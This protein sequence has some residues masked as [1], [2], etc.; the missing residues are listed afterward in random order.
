[1]FIDTH[2]HLDLTDGKENIS[3]IVARA[4][5]AQVSRIINVGIDLPSTKESILLAEQYDGIFATAGI[6]PHSASSIDIAAELAEIE[7]LLTHEKV[8]ALGEVGLDYFRNHATPEDQKK[9]F[10]G[11]LNLYNK[12][13]KPLILHIRD[14]YDDVFD[15]LEAH[16]E[17]PIAGVV[18]CFCGEKKD[19]DRALKLGLHISFTGMITYP[20]ND[21]LRALID[22]VPDDRL[23][24]ETDCPYLAP[25]SKRGKT[26]EPALLPETAET[27]AKERSIKVQDVA[28]I[29][30]HNANTLF[31]LVKNEVAGE[32]VYQIRDAIYINVTKECTNACTFCAKFF[33]DTVKG[34]NLK[35]TVDP[36]VEEAVA[37]VRLYKNCCKE[38]VFCGF[39]EP[40]MRVE[41]VKAVA[42]TLK[43]EG[44]KTR[45]DT[46]GHGNLYNKRNIVPELAG[47]ID[48]VS[49]SVNAPSKEQYNTLCCPLIE[50]DVYEEVLSFVKEARI[51]IPD[52]SITALDLPEVDIEKMETLAASLQVAFRL[53]HYNKV[54]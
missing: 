1:M 33:T 12:Y 38:V 52:V 11:F 28:R 29:T 2:A 36:S 51:H 8:I 23:L 53:R 42:R 41:F 24:L 9:L 18:H 6:H 32:I 13:K 30:T 39:G 20:K 4:Q 22:Y 45:I 25:Q 7:S 5:A 35:L 50:G 48:A 31:A 10:C 15:L 17:L 40:L 26:N 46:N 37:A 27:I 44:W 19:I 49:V 14:A 54:G 3:S 34:H 21:A 16:C 47:L 43:S